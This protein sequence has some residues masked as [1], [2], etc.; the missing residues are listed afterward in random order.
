MAHR[1]LWVRFGGSGTRYIHAVCALRQCH[2]W[3]FRSFIAGGVKPEE[4]DPFHE[5][6]LIDEIAHAGSGGILW[7]L[8]G[9]L[10]I[11]LPPILLFG[12][13]YLQD[14]VA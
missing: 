10:A 5:L 12:S 3:V 1:V 2:F 8:F 9:G 7:G 14:K 4:F 13:K 6:I 11:G